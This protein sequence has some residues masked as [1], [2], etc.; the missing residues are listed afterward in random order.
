MKDKKK[1]NLEQCKQYNIYAHVIYLFQ[2][3]I[4][5]IAQFIQHKWT[6]KQGYFYIGQ[7][8]NIFWEKLNNIIYYKIQ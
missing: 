8:L 3:H 7:R 5:K 6:G 2:H 4:N 1:E